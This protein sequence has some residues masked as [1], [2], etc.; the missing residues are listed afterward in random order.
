MTTLDLFS[1]IGGFSLAASWVWGDDLDIAAFCERDAYCQK[2]LGKHWLGVHIHDDITTL[3][4][5][6]YRGRIDLLTGGFPCQ[7][8]SNTGKRRGAEDDRALWPEM[9]RV[10]DECRPRWIVGENVA[11]IITME[12]DTVLADLENHGYTARAIVVPAVAVDAPHR[13]DRVWIVAYDESEYDRTG[14]ART[15][16]RQAQQPRNGGLSSAMGDA[17]GG[18]WNGAPSTGERGQPARTIGGSGGEALTDADRER[19][20]EPDDAAVAD[21]TGFD[22]RRGDAGGG[23]VPDAAV[24]RG[25]PLRRIEQPGGRDQTG[26]VCLWLSESGMDRTSDGV[27]NRVDRV[28]A[29]GNA[30]VPQVAAEIFRA[31]KEIDA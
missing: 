19:R 3:D 1:G 22:R 30:I 23:D 29:L 28:R 6:I 9:L 10:I 13:R 18:R 25:K 31:I 15:D 17:T 8:F 2:V 11:G 14:A 27:P 24:K 7:P 16:T 5:T 20:E 26:D 4:A 12:L 21:G